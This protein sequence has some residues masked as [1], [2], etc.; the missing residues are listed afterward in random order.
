ML[1]EMFSWGYAHHPFLIGGATLFC[2][3]AFFFFAGVADQPWLRLVLGCVGVLQGV[4][5]AWCFMPLAPRDFALCVERQAHSVAAGYI[6]EAMA[7]G[8]CGARL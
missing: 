4:L 2:S 7:K 5:G 8:H 3:A 1:Y 6:T